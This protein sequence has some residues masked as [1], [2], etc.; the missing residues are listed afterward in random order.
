[1]MIGPSFNLYI[2]EEKIDGE[3]GTLEIPYTINKSEDTN[4]KLS[5]WVGINAGLSLKL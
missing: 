4:G 2:T 5:T 1:M 3:F